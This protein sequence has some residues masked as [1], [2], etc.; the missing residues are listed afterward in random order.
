MPQLKNMKIRRG[1]NVLSDA[2]EENRYPY[3]LSI[4]LDDDS[5][6]KLGINAMPKVGEVFEMVSKVEVT[7][8]SQNETVDGGVERRIG[9]QITDMAFLEP[10]KSDAELFF[11]KQ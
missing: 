1:E 3:G 2:P 10:E 8:V 6:N 7:N 5:I 11:G 9:M 4:S